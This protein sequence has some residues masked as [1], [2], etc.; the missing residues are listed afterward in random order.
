MAPSLA[1]RVPQ[2]CRPSPEP[3]CAK[4]CRSS[5]RAQQPLPRATEASRQRSQGG[6]LPLG[7]EKR[8]SQ[9]GPSPSGVTPAVSPFSPHLGPPARSHAAQGSGRALLPAVHLGQGEHRA[10]TGMFTPCTPTGAGS[11][12]AGQAEPLRLEPKAD[13]SAGATPWLQT[14][15]NRETGAQKPRRK[16]C[17]NRAF[18]TLQV[19]LS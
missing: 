12:G 5:S 13:S 18:T 15:G 17:V 14:T 1:Q 8:V 3:A 16:G 9:E 4:G 11:C 10:P 2:A 19:A 6:M 7:R